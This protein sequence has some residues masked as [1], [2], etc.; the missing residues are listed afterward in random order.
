MIR[1][2]LQSTKKKVFK[3]QEGQT[4]FNPNRKSNATNMTL[5]QL[6]YLCQHVIG[7]KLATKKINKFN[8]LQSC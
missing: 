3:Q 6:V 5:L 4:K 2:E 8:A 7:A 1:N